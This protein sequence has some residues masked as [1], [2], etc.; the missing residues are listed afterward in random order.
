M[1]RNGNRLD[2]FDWKMAKEMVHCGMAY[3]PERHG[4][5]VVGKNSVNVSPIRV[6]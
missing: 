4:I 6:S 1:A 2:Q 3:S 5:V